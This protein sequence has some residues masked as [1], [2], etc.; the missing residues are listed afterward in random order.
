MTWTVELGVT[1]V[2]TPVGA[3]GVLAVDED[4]DVTADLAALVADPGREDRPRLEREVEHLAERCLGPS[5]TGSSAA[6]SAR[7][8]S[9]PGSTTRAV[10]TA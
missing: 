10:M 9:R 1:A 2:C 8:R 4:V 5:S 3:L 6:P 7:S